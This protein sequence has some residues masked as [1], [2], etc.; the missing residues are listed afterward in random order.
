MTQTISDFHNKCK[1]RAEELANRLGV[2]FNPLDVVSI[3]SKTRS[4]IAA[5]QKYRERK[6]EY[7]TLLEHVFTVVSPTEVVEYLRN[8]HNK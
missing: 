3:E 2:D 1:S 6:E 4:R 5:I 8:F 7:D